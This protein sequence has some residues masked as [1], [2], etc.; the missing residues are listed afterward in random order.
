VTTEATDDYQ[1][2]LDAFY[3]DAA[4]R[5]AAH[6]D[7]GRDVVVIAE[8]DPFFYGSYMYLHQRLAHRYETEVIPGV[9]SF[10]A[11][12]AA[13]G[14]RSPSATTYSPC[15]PARCRP[16]PWRRACAGPTPPSCSSSA[17]ASTACAAPPSAPG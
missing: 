3:A 13:A 8:G 11:A 15:C 6:L 7:A 17:A 12:A 4:A 14:R 2:R 16:T 5:L 1:G 9:T 10:S